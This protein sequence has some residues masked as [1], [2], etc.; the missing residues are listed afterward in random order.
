MNQRQ[1]EI[2]IRE[3]IL[4]EQIRLEEEKMKEYA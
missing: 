4:A 3:R 2:A 1:E